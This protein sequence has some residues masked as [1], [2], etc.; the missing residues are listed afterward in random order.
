MFVFYNTT[1][2]VNTPVY[3]M[4]Y[5]VYTNLSAL[6]MQLFPG[7]TGHGLPQGRS[8]GGSFRPFLP[9]S[10]CPRVEAPALGQKLPLFGTRANVLGGVIFV[11]GWKLWWE[12][13]PQ[14]SLSMY[15]Y[16]IQVDLCTMTTTCTN[17]KFNN[18]I[19]NLIMIIV[20]STISYSLSL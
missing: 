2:A 8:S 16:A 12:K 19:S 10:F 4:S 13:H 18:G 9:R 3:R 14:F 20:S 15:D 1:L 7:V 5:R 11:L 6:G 17:I